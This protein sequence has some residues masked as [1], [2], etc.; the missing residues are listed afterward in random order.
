VL[1]SP[2]NA[3]S[4]PAQLVAHWSVE[5]L[6]GSVSAILKVLRGTKRLDSNDAMEHHA[7]VLN[8]MVGRKT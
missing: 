4:S 3:R 8:E 6:R 2:S 7:E 5:N 1:S